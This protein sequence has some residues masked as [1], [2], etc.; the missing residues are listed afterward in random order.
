MALKQFLYEPRRRGDFVSIDSNSNINISKSLVDKLHL[1]QFKAIKLNY[2]DADPIMVLEFLTEKVPLTAPIRTEPTFGIGAKR[3]VRLL[4]AK[5]GRY[6]AEWDDKRKL[7]TCIY[8]V[9]DSE[10]A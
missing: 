10:A 4:K 8:S 9:A 5:P 1:G 7:L 2:D 3:F 6:E